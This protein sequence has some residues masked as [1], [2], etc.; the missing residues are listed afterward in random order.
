MKKLD[1]ARKLTLGRE[2]L[3]AL[4]RTELDQVAGGISGIK[5]VVIPSLC[6]PFGCDRLKSYIQACPPQ[7]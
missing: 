3:L 2:T 5:T 6:T 1:Q 4:D 7:S